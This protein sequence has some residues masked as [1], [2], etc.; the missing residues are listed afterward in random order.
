MIIC[1]ILPI[2]TYI[3]LHVESAGNATAGNATQRE[4]HAGN[5]GCTIWDPIRRKVHLKFFPPKEPTDL[6]LQRTSDD[7]HNGPPRPA[8]PSD[9]K[10]SLS[11]AWSRQGT[12]CQNDTP[13]I[14]LLVLQLLRYLP[15]L[16]NPNKQP[17]QG[18]RKHC[19]MQ[20]MK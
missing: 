4:E 13:N 17:E 12:F 2:H 20:L 14:S 1:R 18:L 10:S 3:Y 19:I 16:V 5:I 7:G 11:V 15:D 6:G 9:G 8:T